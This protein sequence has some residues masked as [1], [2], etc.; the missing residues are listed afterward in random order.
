MSQ[1]ISDEQKVAS[2]EQA[3]TIDAVGE[4]TWA[5]TIGGMSSEGGDG[6]AD[7]DAPARDDPSQPPSSTHRPSPNAATSGLIGDL[8]KHAALSAQLINWALT[9]FEPHDRPVLSGEFVFPDGDA[10][11]DAGHGSTYEECSSEDESEIIE[12]LSKALDI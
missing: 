12:A 3:D 8:Q 9:D 7:G 5:S 6:R 1:C 4:S 10:S 11:S 2:Q